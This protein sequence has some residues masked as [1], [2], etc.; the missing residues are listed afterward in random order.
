MKQVIDSDETIEDVEKFSKLLGRLNV[1]NNTLL[2]K[3]SANVNHYVEVMKGFL[4]RFSKNEVNFCII[5][6]NIRQSKTN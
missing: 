5:T 2:G 3:N 6:R 1:F 4:L